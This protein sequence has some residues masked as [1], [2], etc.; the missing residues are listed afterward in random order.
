MRNKSILCLMMTL[1]P[2]MAR[3]AGYYLGEQDAAAQGRGL[4]VTAKLDSPAVLFF[5]PAGMA[6]LDALQVQVGATLA[7]PDFKYSDPKG[8]RPSESADLKLTVA[9]HLYA[10]YTFAQ[11]GSVGLG[12][13]SP[14]GLRLTWPEGFAGESRSAGV[15][16]KMPTVYLAGAYRPLKWLSVGL[17]FR[18]IPATI[19]ML[20]RFKAVS[21]AGNLDWGFA[22]LAASAVGFGASLGLMAVPIEKLH[23]G[24]SYL[25]RVKF[26]F[27]NGIAHFGLPDGTSDTSTFHDQEGSTTMTTPDV[28]SFGVGYDVNEHLYLEFDYNYTLWSVYDSLAIK[29]DKDPSGVLSK[30]QPKDWRNTSTF[31]LG[32]EYR[33]DQSWALRLAAIYD[34]SPA[35]DSTVGP[36]LPDSSRAVF[37][38]GGGYRHPKLGLRVDLGYTLVY[39]LPR[40]AVTQDQNPF[41]A[42]YKAMAHLFGFSFGL[43]D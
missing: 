38:I 18:V 13:N 16:M 43:G 9:P 32:G 35:P 21:D 17:S 39:F 29:F 14:F 7:L 27:K 24:F 26:D 28:M 20:Q 2:T 19:E 23:L 33:F 4:A 25:S 3:A 5:N 22:H 34:Q 36:E 1:I 30:P 31:R 12:F 42:T 11:K 15:D 37:C 8:Q 40:T 41:P 6:F 10:F